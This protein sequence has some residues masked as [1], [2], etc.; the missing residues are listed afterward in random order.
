M[1]Q[2]IRRITPPPR[3]RTGN[4]RCW[5]Y[6]CG[7]CKQWLLPKRFRKI[8][9]R[10]DRLPTYCFRCERRQRY[11]QEQAVASMRASAAKRREAV[12]R[13][14]Q[15]K[16]FRVSIENIYAEAVRINRETGIEHHVDHEIPLNHPLVCGLH[17]PANLRII[18]ADANLKKSNEFTP[19]RETATARFEA[20]TWRPLREKHRSAER[21]IRV[22]KRCEILESC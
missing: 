2:V 15:H 17:V 5:E 22:I 13:G 11:K 3:R 18:T 8:G 20:D 21:G 12:Y 4:N 16:A 7:D 19:Y 9:R 10:H 6:F 14:S 1:P